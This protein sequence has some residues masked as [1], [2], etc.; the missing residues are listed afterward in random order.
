MKRKLLMTAST[1]SHISNFHLPYLRE[2]QRLGWETH[3]GC[4]GIPADAPF[5][6]E[7]IE[8]PFEKRMQSP[9]NFRAARILR[10]QIQRE[11]YDLIITH[12][13]LA[14][15]FTRLAVKGMRNRLKIINVVHGY[16]FDDETPAIKRRLLLNAERVTASETDL[17]LTMNAYDYATAQKYRLGRQV[18]QIPGMGVDFSKLDQATTE[19][20]AR[21][22]RELG[23]PRDAFV[24]L[25][26]AEFSER[27]SQDVLIEAMTR[28]PK[29]AV[30]VLCGTGA[31]LEDCKALADKLGVSERVLF[32]R[33]IADMGAWYR[34]ADAAVTSSRS[35]GLPFNVM[36]AMHLG[37]PMVASA[38]KG[39]VDLIEDG[40]TG[41]LY[42]YG[43]AAVCA[44]QVKRLMDDPVLREKVRIQGEKSV[45]RYALD[46][47]LPQ[48]MEQYLLLTV[49]YVGQSY[50][51]SLVV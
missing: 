44:A 9:A 5:I 32:P 3:V 35:E 10:G 19:D 16:L 46:R 27:K 25:Y 50:S 11:H 21:L 22:R 18:E 38:V 49:E 15:F 2:F 51:N 12:T 31:L 45:K 36:E 48:V 24:L 34:M 28:L 33:Q 37:L 42:P 29:N 6:D 20:G 26:A 4:K 40:V 8:L 14:A 43:D 13:S 7:T 30:L 1:Y 23:I 39:H 17:L 41:L 47:V